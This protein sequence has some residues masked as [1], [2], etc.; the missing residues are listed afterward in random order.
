MLSFHGLKKMSINSI[1]RMFRDAKS[2]RSSVFFF[3]FESSF[4]LDSHKICL[5]F[6]GISFLRWM[7]SLI[8]KS[9]REETATYKFTT[10]PVT[11]NEW[12]W[13]ENP[14]SRIKMKNISS[15]P[16]TAKRWFSLYMRDVP[17]YIKKIKKRVTKSKLAWHSI[18]E[19]LQRATVQ[20]FLNCLQYVWCHLTVQLKIIFHQS[21]Q[22]QA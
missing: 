6:R 11:H 15:H 12:K 16:H 2:R 8:Q 21:S 13:V 9:D 18:K 17:M 14:G 20:M 3:Q 10:L 5:W 19:E 1:R 7:F 22:N 4:F